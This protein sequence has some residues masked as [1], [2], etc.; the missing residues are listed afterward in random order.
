MHIFNKELPEGQR[1]LQIY[2]TPKHNGFSAL[3]KYDFKSKGIAEYQ[4]IYERRL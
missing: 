2:G 3:L 1:Y 4:R